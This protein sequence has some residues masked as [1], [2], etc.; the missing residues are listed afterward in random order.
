[1][2]SRMLELSY[3]GSDKEQVCKDSAGVA[4]LAG[5]DTV[6]LGCLVIL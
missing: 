2:A 4:Y 5:S 3:K 6:G 1:M